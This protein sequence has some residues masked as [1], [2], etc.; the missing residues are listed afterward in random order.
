MAN[1]TASA[2]GTKRYRAT[3]VRKNIGTKTIQMQSVETNGGRA[4]S[5]A[6]SRIAWIL[7]FPNA[8]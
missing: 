2:K 7:G 8:I 3:P 5:C 6:P 4:I 1:T